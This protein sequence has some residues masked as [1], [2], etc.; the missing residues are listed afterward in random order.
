MIVYTVQE[1]D[2]VICVCDNLLRC[3]EFLNKYYG[4]DVLEFRKDFKD[5]RDSGLECTF[6]LNDDYYLIKYFLLND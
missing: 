1:N 5:I 2:E 3:Y 6:T 4:Y